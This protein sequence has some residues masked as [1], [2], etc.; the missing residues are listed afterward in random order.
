MDLRVVADGKVI[1]HLG[2]NRALG[3]PIGAVRR[4]IEFWFSGRVNPRLPLLCRFT[5]FLFGICQI[6]R[7][8]R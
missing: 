3:T 1:D 6:R 4:I 8:G 5:E 7:Q 2:A